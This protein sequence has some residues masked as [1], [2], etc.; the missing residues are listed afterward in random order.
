[1]MPGMPPQQ[2]PQQQQRPGMPNAPLVNPQQLAAARARGGVPIPQQGGYKFAQNARNTPGGPMM[3][4]MPMPMGGMP[5]KPQLNAST[6]ASLPADQ[7]KRMLGE[8]LFPLIEQRAKNLAGKVTG[9]LLEMDNGELLHLLE[10]PEALMGKVNEAV[11]VLEEHMSSMQG[12]AE[13]KGAA[14]VAGESA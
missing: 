12:G 9:M 1:M 14:V 8:A 2:Q 5:G 11:A 13:E 10:S 4:P 3:P 7:Q 6:L